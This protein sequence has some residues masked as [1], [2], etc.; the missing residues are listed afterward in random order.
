MTNKYDTMIKF[1]DDLDKTI[2]GYADKLIE[3]EPEKS[4]HRYAMQYGYV[5]GSLFGIFLALDLTEDQVLK[6]EN[7]MNT[8]V[9]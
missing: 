3:A 6:L 2:V 5:T 4:S 7:H 8:L 1:V 9:K